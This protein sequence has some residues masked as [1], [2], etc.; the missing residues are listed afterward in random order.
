MHAVSL[1]DDVGMTEAQ[2]QNGWHSTLGAD[3]WHWNTATSRTT[4]T[5]TIT[6]SGGNVTTQTRDVVLT[7]CGRINC[8]SY[9]TYTDVY[10]K[11]LTQQQ[12]FKLQLDLTLQNHQIETII[13]Q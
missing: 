2:I 6:D 4:M 1:K 13:G 9:D 11:N 8:G 5:Q 12:T 10:F 7:S 3:I